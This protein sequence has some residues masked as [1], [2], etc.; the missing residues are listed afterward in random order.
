MALHVAV[1]ANKH[2]ARKCGTTLSKAVSS[3]KITEVNG[4]IRHKEKLVSIPVFYVS[5]IQL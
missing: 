2:E 4:K 1:M 5:F 3:I